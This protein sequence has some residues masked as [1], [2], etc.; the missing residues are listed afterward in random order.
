MLNN[1]PFSKLDAYNNEAYRCATKEYDLI[2]DAKAIS[3]LNI[4]ILSFTFAS[5]YNH[6]L[7]IVG[8][9][10]GDIEAWLQDLY[11]KED[12]KK[13]WDILWQYRE[14]LSRELFNVYG[15]DDIKLYNN[16]IASINREVK[17]EYEENVIINPIDNE[18]NSHNKYEEVMG[19]VL[20]R[21]N[22]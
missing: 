17:N 6:F 2:K 22:W 20:G 14:I 19:F 18:A 16:L 5:I 7:H 15:N 4:D 10:E 3:E 12:V 11:K 1:Y 13:E 9:S 21:F 8:Y